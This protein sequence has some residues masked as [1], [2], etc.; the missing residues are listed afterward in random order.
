MKRIINLE[1]NMVEVD[2]ILAMSV[3][4]SSNNGSTNQIK[5]T[6]K[7]R[8]EYIYNPNLDIY[9]MEVFNDE[10]FIDYYDYATAEDYLNLFMAEWEAVL[11]ME[12]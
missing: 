2:K 9:E 8:K 11:N 7:T 1:N 4:S 10:L 6:F 5:I 12:E 3:N